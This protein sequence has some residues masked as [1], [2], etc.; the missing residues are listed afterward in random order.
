MHWIKWDEKYHNLDLITR[1]EVRAHCLVTDR[2]AM[3]YEVVAYYPF[4][5]PASMYSDTEAMEAHT[6]IATLPTKE[7]AHSEI[8]RLLVLQNA[9]YEAIK[10]RKEEKTD[11]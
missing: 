1:L 9:D 8:Y 2:G 11:D 7:E 3:L 10:Q 5:Y 4:G 6:I